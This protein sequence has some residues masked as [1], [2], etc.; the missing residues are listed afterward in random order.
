MLSD[1]WSGISVLWKLDALMPTGS[2]KD[3]G[4]SIM[5]NWLAGFDVKVVVDDS[6]GNA[7]NGSPVRF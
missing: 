4:V 1:T 7:G 3:R 5:V 6:S 2:Y